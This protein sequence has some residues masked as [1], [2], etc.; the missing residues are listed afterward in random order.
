[1]ERSQTQRQR[2]KAA[3]EIQKSYHPTAGMF[4][5][6]QTTPAISR[7][8]E[9]GLMC[10]AAPLNQTPECGGNHCKETMNLILTLSVSVLL[11][12][13]PLLAFVHLGL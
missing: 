7:K 12:C 10:L 13:V 6:S 1:M 8:R 11:S 5:L 9:G 2:E 3:K 4:W